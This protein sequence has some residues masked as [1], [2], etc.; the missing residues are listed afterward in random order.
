MTTQFVIVHHS[1]PIKNANGFDK[2]GIKLIGTAP[3]LLE[4]RDLVK[5]TIKNNGQTPLM[6]RMLSHSELF[7]AED[8]QG[9][10]HTYNISKRNV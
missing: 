1:P 4:A 8:V 6:S 2:I 9:K 3:S 10:I 5:E 7:E